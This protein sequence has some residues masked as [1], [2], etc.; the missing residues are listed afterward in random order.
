M[1][2]LHFPVYMKRI[3]SP[4]Y[5]FHFITEDRK[6]GGHVLEP[7]LQNAEVEVD[8]TTQLYMVL[9]EHGEFY[10]VDLTK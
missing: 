2:G 5:Y 1:V 4:G 8:Y 7:Q 10:K 9:Q 6:A 3:N